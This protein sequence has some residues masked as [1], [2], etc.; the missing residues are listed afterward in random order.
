VLERVWDGAE[1]RRCEILQRTMTTAPDAG[2]W[3]QAVPSPWLGVFYT[4]MYMKADD[5][6]GGGGGGRSKQ[7]QQPRRRQVNVKQRG[8]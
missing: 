6:G 2:A 4:C 8:S 3:C 1:L 5:T 7:Q